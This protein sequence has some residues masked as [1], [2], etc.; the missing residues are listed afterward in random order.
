VAFLALSSLMERRAQQ[1][2][3]ERSLRFVGGLA[4][5][6]ETIVVYVLFCVLPGSARVIA[7]VFAVAV[8]ITAIQRLWWGVRLLRRPVSAVQGS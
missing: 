8:A 3:D 6:A 2:G 7:W 1:F 4:E 5:G